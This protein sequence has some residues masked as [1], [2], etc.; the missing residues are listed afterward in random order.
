MTTRH[1]D[2]GSF[3]ARSEHATNAPSFRLAFLRIPHT[4]ARHVSLTKAHSKRHAI[5]PQG[6]DIYRH[7]VSGIFLSP[8]EYFS[9]HSLT[10][11]YT[12]YLVIQ[13]YC[14]TPVG[15]FHTNFTRSRTTRAPHPHHH[16]PVLHL[17]LALRSA[18]PGS[19]YFKPTTCNA[20]GGRINIW[21]GKHAQPPPFTRI[22][23]PSSIAR[24]THP[25]V[26][27]GTKFPTPP[28]YTFR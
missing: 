11:Y 10:R 9:P 17:T 2:L 21:P 7:T 22:W 15:R 25:N 20:P 19:W 3:F 12:R 26:F 18:I 6:S 13:K 4:G 16:I 23:F 28:P 27:L 5:T 24:H 1:S 14:Q 8:L